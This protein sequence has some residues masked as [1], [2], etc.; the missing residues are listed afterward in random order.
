MDA[1]H[2]LHLL[3]SYH[4]VSKFKLNKM[5]CRHF[6]TT[7]TLT[8]DMKES[9]CVYCGRVVRYEIPNINSLERRTRVEDTIKE[10]NDNSE[11]EQNY[12]SE[13]IK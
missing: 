9:S 7:R 8:K 3:G 2:R 1:K 5:G 6:M 13:D 12:S 10:Q 11:Q 4:K